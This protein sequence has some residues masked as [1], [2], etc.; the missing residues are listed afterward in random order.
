MELPW[1]E[2]IHASLPGNI[3]VVALTSE[4]ASDLSSYKTS[5]GLSFPIGFSADLTAFLAGK[6]VDIK[7]YPTTLVFNKQ[8][9]I[10]YTQAGY[11][12]LQSQL[13][14][15]VDYLQ[16]S[17]SSAAATSYTLV[18]RNRDNQPIPGVV[19]YFYGA[20]V[21]QM[22]TS[23]KDG[24]IVFTATPADYHYQVMNDAEEV[25]GKVESW[26]MVEV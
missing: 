2:S 6:G 13:R 3:K 16:R 15:V 14:S 9:S 10:I 5:F 8:G 18:I 11:F 17:P 21:G 19:V 4:S 7:D 24:L 25:E 23:D 22:L 1:F 26:T 20:G 12:R